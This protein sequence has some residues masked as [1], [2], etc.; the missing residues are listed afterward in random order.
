MK[1]LVEKVACFA[2]VKRLAGKIISE[3]ILKDVKPHS[4]WLTWHRLLHCTANHLIKLLLLLLLM[5]MMMLC[6]SRLLLIAVNQWVH[7]RR[8]HRISAGRHSRHGCTAVPGAQS[9]SGV[10]DGMHWSPAHTET[11]PASDAAQGS[12][13]IL[14]L[15]NG[16]EGRQL[17]VRYHL[18]DPDELSVNNAHTICR[19]RLYSFSTCNSAVR[20]HRNR[21]AGGTLAKISHTHYSGSAFVRFWHAPLRERRTKRRHQSPEWTILSHINYFI[22]GEVIGFQVLL[23]SLRPHSTRVSRWSLPVL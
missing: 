15:V 5:M 14:G 12:T 19:W 13:A 18:A 9:D 10:A 3:M 23:D 1:W 20:W 2:P 8:R 6:I 7:Y 17:Q 11:V 21:H 4:I 16:H 22:Q